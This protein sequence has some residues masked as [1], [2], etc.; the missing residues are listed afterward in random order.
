LAAN[1]C[2]RWKKIIMFRKG[3]RK[4]DFEKLYANRQKMQNTIDEKLSANECESGNVEMQWN[5]IK[6]CVLCTMSYLVGKV[7]RRRR[8][9]RNK[10]IMTSKVDKRRM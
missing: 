7:E 1:I 6:I 10:Q 5:D 4:C 8:K 9:P 3:K 2:S